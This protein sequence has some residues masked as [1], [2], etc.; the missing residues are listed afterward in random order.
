MKDFDVKKWADENERIARKTFENWLK[1]HPLT[2]KPEKY[3]ENKPPCDKFMLIQQ[4][5]K[6][7]VCGNCGK[8]P[9]PKNPPKKSC[10]ICGGEM[11]LIRGRYPKQDNRF[12][13][14][15]CDR[16][17][18]EQIQRISDKDYGKTYQDRQV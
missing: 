6:K 8:E 11:V 4:Q 2:E 14:P 7:W 18:L 16:E 17:R 5:D 15:T 12:S 1:D 9:K 13:C 3:C 10:G